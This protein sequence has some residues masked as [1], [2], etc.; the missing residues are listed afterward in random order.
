MIN[1]LNKFTRFDTKRNSYTLID[2]ILLSKSLSHIVENCSILHPPLNVSDHLPIEITVNVEIGE[3]YEE[4]SQ[5]SHF[6]PWSSLTANELSNYRDTMTSA[7][8]QISIPFHV[9]NH[10]SALCGDVGCSLALEKFYDDIIRAVNQADK[11]LPRTKHG[12]AKPYWTPELM[13][14]K[15]QSV[16]AHDLWSSCG[17]PRSG[18]IFAEKQRISNQ[19]KCVLRQSKNI[20]KSSMSDEMGM[21]LQSKDFNSFWRNWKQFNGKDT[22]HSSMIDGYVDHGEIAD[23]FANVFKGIYK[24]SV[25]NDKLRESFEGNFPS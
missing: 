12:L 1:P 16:D 8:S 24:G 18:P 5:I 9:L 7:L 25:A 14:L 19:Y 6:I 22:S 3:F 11:C 13:A 4:K 21:N 15:R 23:N 17:R 10:G 20:D 2:G